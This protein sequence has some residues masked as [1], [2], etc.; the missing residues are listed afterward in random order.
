M[1]VG[2]NLS[3][4]RLAAAAELWLGKPV[5]AIN[6][7]TWW[8]A[9]RENGTADRFEGFGRLLE[10]HRGFYAGAMAQFP[11]VRFS[12]WHGARLDG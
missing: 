5:S 9:L 8:H 12:Q 2:R 6:A 7:A 3:S 10:R 4:V 11:A 1:Q